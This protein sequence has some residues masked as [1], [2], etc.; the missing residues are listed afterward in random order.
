MAFVV[1]LS[2][3]ELE[4]LNILHSP[5]QTM[6][7]AQHRRHILTTPFFIHAGPIRHNAEQIITPAVMI[8]A[9][10]RTTC[11]ILVHVDHSSKATLHTSTK[12]KLFVVKFDPLDVMFIRIEDGAW[13]PSSWS[14]CSSIYEVLNG[15][16]L[17]RSI[18]VLTAN[19]AAL[20]LRSPLTYASM[21]P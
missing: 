19:S 2:S 18:A 12:L 13:A 11:P 7:K 4:P 10:V 16:T 3:K 21:A 1:S 20:S 15:S 14:F 8:V 5:L 6:F 17:S 9:E